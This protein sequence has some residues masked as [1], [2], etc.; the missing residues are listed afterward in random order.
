MQTTTLETEPRDTTNVNFC[1]F[2]TRVR[3][4][5]N[6]GLDLLKKKPF[7]SAKQCGKLPWLRPKLCKE[8]QERSDFWRGCEMRVEINNFIN[9]FFSRLRANLSG[10]VPPS[11]GILFEQLSLFLST[12]LKIFSW[13]SYLEVQ[14]ILLHESINYFIS[15]VEE[16]YV[17]CDVP[18]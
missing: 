1:C 17:L 15:S 6:F 4:R 14:F 13:D 8:T 2:P 16:V 9:S 18:S 3:R 12:S 7:T 10:Q 5:P 11:R